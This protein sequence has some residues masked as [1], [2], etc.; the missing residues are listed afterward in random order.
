MIILTDAEREKFA[1]YLLQEAK[2][3]D[4]MAQQTV[5]ANLPAIMTRMFREE[6]AASMIVQRKLVSWEK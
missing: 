3:A 5:K 6:A 1:A 4:G 2:T